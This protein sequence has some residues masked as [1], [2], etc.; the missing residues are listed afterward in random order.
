MGAYNVNA[1]SLTEEENMEL[2]RKYCPE[3]SKLR[4]AQMELFNM[5]LVL[6]DICRKHKIQWWL[7]SG[8]LLGAARHQ[9]FIPW[10]DDVDI[11][12]LKK[13]YKRLENVLMSMQSDEYVLHSMKTDIEYINVFAKFRRKEGHDLSKDRRRNF[14]RWCGVFVDIFAIEKNNYAAARLS[15]VVYHNIQHL[16][17]YIQA[18]WL[19]RVLIR[20]VQ[21]LCLFILNPIL[22]I[23]GLVNPKEEYHYVL[24]LGWAKSTFFLKDIFPLKTAKFEGVDLPVP[25]DMDTYLTNVYGDWRKLPT[26][27]QIRKSLH[28][29]VYIKEIFGEE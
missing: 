4:E 15:K 5:L 23:V 26:D 9:G 17:S 10:D 28:N 8:T 16:T 19:R 13:D 12:M 29:P 25:N 14:Y 20:F 1:H 7:S 6:A 21:F 24:G 18:K 11:V 2:R 22:R 27:E 3:G